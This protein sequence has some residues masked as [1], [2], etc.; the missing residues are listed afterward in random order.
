MQGSPLPTIFRLVF[1]PT[2][3]WPS[4]LSFC[5]EWSAFLQ[6]QRKGWGGNSMLST[7][8]VS[9]ACV[10]W[11]WFWCCCRHLFSLLKSCHLHYLLWNS[12]KIKFSKAVRIAV[13]VNAVDVC[14]APSHGMLWTVPASSLVSHHS[15]HCSSLQMPYLLLNPSMSEIRP[16]MYPV[17]FGESIEVN[18]EPVQEIRYRWYRVG[19]V[20]MSVL[21]LVL[22]LLQKFKCDYK[23]ESWLFG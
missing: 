9:L 4:P 16:R 19:G 3:E 1:F 5:V 12:E 11:N 23:W 17:F 22:F 7:S 21:F 10:Q 20:G 13:S 8:R 14:S 18:P 6:T 15:Q 2:W